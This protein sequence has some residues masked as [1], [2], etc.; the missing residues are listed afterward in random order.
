MCRFRSRS[1]Q[2]FFLGFRYTNT[3]PLLWCIALIVGHILETR[4]TIHVPTT[5]GRITLRCSPTR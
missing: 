2:K 4:D 3:R 5:E 1:P